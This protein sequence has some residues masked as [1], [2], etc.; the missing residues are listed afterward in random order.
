MKQ[1]DGSVEKC[2][3]VLL[4]VMAIAVLAACGGGGGGGGSVDPAY[5][6]QNGGPGPAGASPGLGVAAPYAL[7]A[8]S[9][10]VTLDPT[11]RVSGNV[12]LSPIAATCT[13]CT[14]GGTITTGVIENGTPAALAAQVAFNAAYVDAANRATNA[15]IIANAELSSA[16]ASCAGVI[17]GPTYAPGLYKYGS[18]LHIG[19]TITLDAKG[20]PNAVFIFQADSTLIT[21]TGSKILLANGAQAKNV[22]WMVG[23]AA[24]L[25]NNSQFKGTVLANGAA[26][27]VNTSA[28]GFPTVIEGRLLSHAA[29]ITVGAYTTITLPP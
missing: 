27:T 1:F 16:Q 28:V 7:F 13:N 4:S 24:T 2:G 23:S 12:G 5:S 6:L 19:S 8:S 17:N 14:I 10:A 22:W 26:I 20:Y 21:S 9:A 18:G 11:T 29:A 15:C 3:K 25:A